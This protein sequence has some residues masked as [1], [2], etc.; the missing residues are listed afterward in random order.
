[1]REKKTH[2][3]TRDEEY[4]TGFTWNNYIVF[5]YTKLKN[6]NK[7]QQP[8]GCYNQCGTIEGKQ[9]RKPQQ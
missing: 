1:M 7:Q 5:C 6:N 8:K 2:T 3:L 9:K 4:S